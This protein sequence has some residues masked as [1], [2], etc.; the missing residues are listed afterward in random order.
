[1]SEP[2]GDSPDS[3]SAGE[4]GLPGGS[5]DY[6]AASPASDGSGVEWTGVRV[7]P[8]VFVEAI[9]SPLYVSP[10]GVNFYEVPEGANVLDFLVGLA[11]NQDPEP[12]SK[13]S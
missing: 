12:V 8:A 7:D 5:D 13:K 4:P 1:M 2:R 10:D 3:P 11:G 9:L 6:R